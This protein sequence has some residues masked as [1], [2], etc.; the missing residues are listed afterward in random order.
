VDFAKFGPI[1]PKPLPRIKKISAA[2][3]HRNWV[4]IPH[5][6]NSDEADVTELE[7]FRIQLNK[8]N[9][10]AGL[11]LTMLAFLAKACVH[12]L[13]K[14]PELNSSLDGDSLVYKRYYHI[15]FAADTPM[16]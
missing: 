11:K 13:K 2:N 16:G 8:E 5:V 1:E 15:G 3:L 10:K 4:M 14:F 7:P 9:E 6:T 12:A